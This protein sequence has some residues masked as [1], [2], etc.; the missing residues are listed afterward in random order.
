[1]GKVLELLTSFSFL[2]AFSAHLVQVSIF[3]VCLH[4]V[5]EMQFAFALLPATV[6]IAIA[7]ATHPMYL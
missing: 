4:G 5:G 7:V 2:T 3:A 1:L 6:F